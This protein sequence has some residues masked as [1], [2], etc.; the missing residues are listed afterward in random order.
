MSHLGK[1]RISQCYEDKRWQSLVLQLQQQSSFLACTIE[2]QSCDVI[3]IY[4]RIFVF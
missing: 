4:F 2:C 1:I 3:K